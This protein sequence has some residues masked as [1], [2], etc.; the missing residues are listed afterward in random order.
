MSKV[1]QDSYHIV[2]GSCQDRE[3][4]YNVVWSVVS[5]TPDGVEYKE[6]SIEELKGRYMVNGIGIETGVM[7]LLVRDYY[8]GLKGNLGTAADPA[9]TSAV[10]NELSLA[11]CSCHLG[12]IQ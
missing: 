6:E 1:C 3:D 2:G 11:Y 4:L 12:G 5:S 10:T 7:R 8:L 9:S